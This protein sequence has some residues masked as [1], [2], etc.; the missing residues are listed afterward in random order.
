V[1]A[2][3]KTEATVPAGGPWAEAAFQ[4]W[5]RLPRRFNDGFAR[6]MLAI[7]RHHRVPKRAIWA[8]TAFARLARFIGPCP[9]HAFSVSSEPTLLQLADS[10]RTKSTA[11]SS[12]TSDDRMQN[13]YA[14]FWPGFL[15]HLA[16]SNSTPA[17]LPEGRRTA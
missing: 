11:V 14:P 6:R 4:T 15:L 17:G 9:R 1:R 13:P 7:Y 5:R 3:P 16:P 8:R 2:C 12:Q 10:L